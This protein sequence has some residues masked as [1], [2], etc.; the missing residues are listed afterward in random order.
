[1][2][3]KHDTGIQSRPVDLFLILSPAILA[4]LIVIP[5]LSSAEFGLLCDGNTLVAVRQMG[6]GIYPMW[7]IQGR[8]S[9]P[10]YWIYWFIIG[11]LAGQD[12]FLYYLLQS[13][14]LFFLV[15]AL[16]YFYR[17]ISTNKIIAWL[18]GILFVLSGPVIENFY[19]LS[20]SEPLALFWLVLSLIS[21]DRYS[22]RRS[23]LIKS[24]LFLQ[25]TLFI[26]LS[27]ASKE[28]ALVILPISA[29]WLLV[30]VLRQS[31][32]IFDHNKALAY[33]LAGLFAALFFVVMRSLMVGGDLIG[34]GY[35]DQ[36]QFTLARLFS[37][38]SRWAAW[39]FHDF[40]Y[41]IPMCVFL[42]VRL[43]RKEH[44][45]Q[46]NILLMG[47]IWM[48]GWVSVYLFWIF[49]ADY[50]LLPFAAGI[51][52]FSAILLFEMISHC[53]KNLRVTSPAFILILIFIGLFLTTLP[54]NV[55]MARQQLKVDSANAQ[56]VDYFSEHLEPE[57]SVMM[58]IPDQS[59]YLEQLG[60]LLEEIY[61][62]EVSFVGV[63]PEAEV[64]ATIPNLSIKVISRIENQVLLSPRLGL[65]D[66]VQDEINKANEVDA[67]SDQKLEKFISQSYRILNVDLPR[68]VCPLVKPVTELNGSTNLNALSSI[69]VYCS[70][71]PLLDRRMFKYQ[72]LIYRQ[73]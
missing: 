45:P 43:I 38:G 71:A 44:I 23:R 64:S 55:T 19:T 29:G 60:L 59:E 13:V 15:V 9:R 27:V 8:R 6:S 31:N 26:F 49:V 32:S 63:D 25:T 36:F 41:V 16:V 53:R 24:A 62:L 57:Q 46:L 69:D 20:K 2:I 5:R 48:A 28:T 17:T 3:K 72:W 21:I 4:V 58:L 67:L 54:N 61:G 35:S 42:L 7:D 10:V 70:S 33:F 66:R 65:Y 40:A 12:P 34:S 14:F 68:I 22:D 39:I 73:E 18:G 56:L 37:S 11:S 30:S 1:M 52:I 47:L 51:A 50:Y